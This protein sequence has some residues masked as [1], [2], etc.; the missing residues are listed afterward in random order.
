MR[1]RGDYAD[2]LLV[3]LTGKRMTREEQGGHKLEA[4]GRGAE[5]EAGEQRPG[6]SPANLPADVYNTTF[7]L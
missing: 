5:D 1:W 7:F 4:R 6:G 2:E 3:L